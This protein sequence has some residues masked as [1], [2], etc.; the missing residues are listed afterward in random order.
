MP[1]YSQFS[2]DTQRKEGEFRSHHHRVIAHNEEIAFY[3][4]GEREKEILNESFSSLR[5]LFNKIFSYQMGMGIVDQYLVKYG[6]TMVAYSMMMPAVYLGLHGLAGKSAPEIMQ[7]YI[8]SSALFVAL[9]NACKHL[10]LSYKHIH[11]PTPP[12]LSLLYYY[13][14]Y[15]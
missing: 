3:G 6:A 1:P 11:V 15:Y 10:V 13:Y 14:Y 2:A 4:G 7:Y 8:T 12:P 9:G 5:Q